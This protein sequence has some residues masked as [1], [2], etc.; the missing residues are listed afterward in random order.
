MWPSKAPCDGILLHVSTNKI[1]RAT[2]QNKQFSAL[3]PIT[4][5][6]AAA[7]FVLARII[8]KSKNQNS[9]GP[10]QSII[11]SVSFEKAYSSFKILIISIINHL[12]TY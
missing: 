5:Q 3:A 8:N 10:L 6:L 9:I 12:Q 11:H 2:N 4:A 7:S 1:L